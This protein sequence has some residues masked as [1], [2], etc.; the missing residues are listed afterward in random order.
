MMFWTKIGCR[1]QQR[2]LPGQQTNATQHI[3]D[4]GTICHQLLTPSLTLA[5]PFVGEGIYQNLWQNT[6]ICSQR[7]SWIKVVKCTEFDPVDNLSSRLFSP[8]ISICCR[9]SVFNHFLPPLQLQLSVSPGNIL[10]FDNNLF[11][12][13]SIKITHYWSLFSSSDQIFW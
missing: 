1:S 5:F 4:T 2:E 11:K 3:L 13:Y 9:H 7:L 10:H 8:V 12:L 6:T